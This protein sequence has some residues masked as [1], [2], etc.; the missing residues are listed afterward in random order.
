MESREE[1]AMRILTQVTL[2]LTACVQLRHI[3]NITIGKS[4]SVSQPVKYLFE[5]ILVNTA[6]LGL[7]KWLEFYRSYREIIPTTILEHSDNLN[8]EINR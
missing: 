3:K 7:C 6:I 2:D 8:S 5:Q 1:Q 4:E